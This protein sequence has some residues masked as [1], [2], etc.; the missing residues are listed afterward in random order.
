MWRN[1]QYNHGNC[2]N[3]TRFT[4]P[5][6]GWYAFYVHGYRATEFGDVTLKVKGEKWLYVV[7]KSVKGKTGPR[8][9]IVLWL[10]YKFNFA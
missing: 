10:N 6:K 7:G 9:Q 8:D 4:A 1:I 5:K 2:F 3:G